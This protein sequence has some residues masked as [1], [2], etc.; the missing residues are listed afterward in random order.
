[1]RASPS[2]AMRRGAAFSE[3][4]VH[5]CP[6][7]RVTPRRWPTRAKMRPSGAEP[8]ISWARVHGP[9]AGRKV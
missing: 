8:T 4:T 1:M 3:T 5:V 7:S 2:V 6:P 9:A